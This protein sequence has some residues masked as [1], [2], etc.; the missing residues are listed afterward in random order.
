[1]AYWLWRRVLITSYTAC[2]RAGMHTDMCLWAC[3]SG[4]DH[5]GPTLLKCQ[6]YAGLRPT[7]ERPWRRRSTA[8]HPADRSVHNEST[9]NIACL[10]IKGHDSPIYSNDGSRADKGQ[11]S[12]WF[13]V[14]LFIQGVARL[15]IEH[16]NSGVGC[17]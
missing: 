3:A 12:P 15:F 7:A 2:L 4:Q 10:F 6:H 5:S 11:Y 8:N 17:M 14:D 13:M 9:T 16:C 1:M